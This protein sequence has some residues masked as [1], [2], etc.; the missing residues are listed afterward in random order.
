MKYT[1]GI[2]SK[3]VGLF[4]F[5]K[6]PHDQQIRSVTTQPANVPYRVTYTYDVDV[7]EAVNP[8]DHDLATVVRRY[9]GIKID[10]AQ[11]KLGGSDWGRPDL[12]PPHYH[13]MKEDVL[14][15]LS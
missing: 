1:I 14:H 12:S 11:T 4:P 2:P 9:L 15:L 8:I 13:Y 6:A 5:V 7:E 3:S 10:K